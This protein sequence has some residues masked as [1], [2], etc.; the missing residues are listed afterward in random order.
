MCCIVSFSFDFF[1]RELIDTLADCDTI[2]MFVNSLLL[3]ECSFTVCGYVEQCAQTY[4]S[5]GM[6]HCCAS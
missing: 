5:G 1:F 2:K 3:A 6:L 4:I